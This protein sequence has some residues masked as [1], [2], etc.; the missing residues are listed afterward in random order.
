MMTTITSNH[1]ECSNPVI[2]FQSW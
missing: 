2:C 1:T